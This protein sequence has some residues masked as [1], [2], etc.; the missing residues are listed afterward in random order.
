M[1]SQIWYIFGTTASSIATC[2]GSKASPFFIIFY[3]IGFPSPQIDQSKASCVCLTWACAAFSLC[4]NLMLIYFFASKVMSKRLVIPPWMHSYNFSKMFFKN[5]W[6]IFHIIEN[7]VAHAH[8]HAHVCT[9]HTYTRI[10]SLQVGFCDPFLGEDILCILSLFL[11]CSGSKHPL[12]KPL[13]E[14]DALLQTLRSCPLHINK[15]S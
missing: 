9:P 12:G 5:D 7:E 15:S 2:Q 4:S 11:R 6:L 8:T 13:A 14:S 3:H 1:R 10:T